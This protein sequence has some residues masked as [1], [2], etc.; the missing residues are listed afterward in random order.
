MNFKDILLRSNLIRF[1]ATGRRSNGTLGQLGWLDVNFERLLISGDNPAPWFTYGAIEYIDQTVAP[2]LKVLEL[3]GGASTK[4]WL[5]RGNK[6]VTIESDPS[7]ASQLE[8]EL[9]NY[10]E[11]EM[12][13]IQDINSH[14]LARLEG[15][16]FDVIVNDF[17]GGT[18]R[19][20]LNQWM[21][22]HLAVG[23]VIIWDNSDRK[24]YAKAIRDL[25]ELGFGKLSFFGLGPV[26]SYAWETSI[27]SRSIKS[28]AWKTRSNSTIN[29]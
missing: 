12:H 14:S 11:W 26:N 29:Y 17:N 18:G 3:G 25:E 13:L 22:D 8:T 6:T 19:E 21:L 20:N 2:S 28:P 4:Y 1:L 27:L 9:A 10:P 15:Q 5:D 7:W 24:A 23:G 16:K